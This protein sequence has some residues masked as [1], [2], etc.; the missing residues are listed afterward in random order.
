MG[1]TTLL[2]HIAARKL[3]IPPNI[4]VLLCE[5]GND[6][7]KIFGHE[8][9]Y[10][11]VTWLLPS[12]CVAFSQSITS[13]LFQCHNWDEGYW[14]SHFFYSGYLLQNWL[15]IANFWIKTKQWFQQSNNEKVS[16]QVCNTPQHCCWTV[17]LVHSKNHLSPNSI[18]I[19]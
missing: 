16:R 1:K 9:E 2:S 12:S 4:D 19:S 8:C 11:C 17:S 7:F 13:S 10:S 15:I 3:A 14:Q 5:Q 6:I 18:L